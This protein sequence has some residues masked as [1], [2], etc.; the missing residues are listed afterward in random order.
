VDF[1]W[2]PIETSIKSSEILLSS[3]D[4]PMS[5]QRIFPSKPCLFGLGTLQEDPRGAQE[6][7]QVFLGTHLCWMKNSVKTI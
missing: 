7:S 6:K 5:F 3:Q 2:F 4:F 1:P